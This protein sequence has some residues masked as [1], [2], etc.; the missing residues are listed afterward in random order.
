[1]TYLSDK[2]RARIDDIQEV[3]EATIE[4]CLEKGWEKKVDQLPSTILQPLRTTPQSL[5]LPLGS[6]SPQDSPLMTASE[7]SLLSDLRTAFQGLKGF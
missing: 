4:R 6:H 7:A 3:P 5:P 1:M 2:E